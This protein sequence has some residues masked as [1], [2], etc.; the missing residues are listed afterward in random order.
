MSMARMITDAEL[1]AFL[2]GELPPAR[3]AEVAAIAQC[4]G[5]MQSKLKI[6]RAQ[7]QWLRATFAPLAHEPVPDLLTQALP[8]DRAPPFPHRVESLSPHIVPRDETLVW[9]MISLTLGVLLFATALYASGLVPGASH[10]QTI[11][12]EKW[13]DQPRSLR[14]S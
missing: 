2:D 3:A 1:V 9:K 14:G 8:A 4:N 7:D 12:I 13:M 6:W 5:Q 11:T 10:G